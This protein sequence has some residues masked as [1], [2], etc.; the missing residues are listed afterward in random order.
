MLLYLVFR[1]QI[2]ML[3]EGEIP[4]DCEGQPAQ[5]EA[6]REEEEDPAPVEVDEG[7]E[8]VLKSNS[9]TFYMLLFR[10][11]PSPKNPKNKICAKHFHIKKASDKIL[12][13][14]TPVVNLTNILQ[15][16]LVQIYFYQKITNQNCKHRKAIGTDSC[17]QLFAKWR[18]SA[19]LK[20]SQLI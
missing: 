6:S 12:V 18:P 13:K 5:K 19:H 17:L 15:T 7:D 8:D 3:E 2:S 20:L 9:P 10:K 1:V 4:D 16:A 14:F 11:F